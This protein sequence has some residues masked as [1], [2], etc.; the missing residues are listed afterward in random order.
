MGTNERPNVIFFNPPRGKQYQEAC[1][2]W[3]GR[4]LGYVFYADDFTAF[5]EIALRGTTHWAVLILTDETA[6][7]YEPEIE[8]FRLSNEGVRV[9]IE[10]DAGVEGAA[11][12]GRREALWGPVLPD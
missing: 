10:H 8:E 11:R 3:F 12:R 6:S 4:A 2:R 1:T 7:A 9:G 5:S